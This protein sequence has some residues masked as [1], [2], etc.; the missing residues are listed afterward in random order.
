MLYRI[1]IAAY[2]LINIAGGLMAYLMPSSRS[3]K[4]LIVGGIAGLLLL[5]CAAMA[6]TKPSVAFRGAAAIALVLAGFW[7]YRINDVVAQGKS[8]MMSIGNLVLAVAVFAT[9]G[10]GHMLGMKNRKA[11]PESRP[12]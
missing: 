6:K 3:V 11:E 2:G 7:I 8:P 12:S 5:A 10:I 9:L 1:V 4:S